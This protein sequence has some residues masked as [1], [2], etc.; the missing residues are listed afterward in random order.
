MNVK[1]QHIV[2]GM[3]T[4]MNVSKFDATKVLYA[5]NIRITQQDN[6][7]G[8]MCV[9][10]EKGTVQCTFDDTIPEGSIVGSAEL[11][12][13]LV[14]FLHTEVSGTPYDSIVKLNPVGDNQFHPVTLM[15]GSDLGFDTEHPLETLAVYENE[16]VQKVYWIDGVHTLR[17]INIADETQRDITDLTQFDANP[18]LELA[19]SLSITKRN[20]GGEFPAGT[21][22]YAFTYHNQYGPESNVFEASPLYELSSKTKGVAADGRTNCSFLINLTNTDTKYK[23]VRIYAIIRT[24]E[25]ATPNVRLLGDFNNDKIN[26]SDTGGTVTVVDD[27]SLG[28]TIDATSLYFVGGEP[29]A[30]STFTV[31]DNTLFLGNI[32]LLRPSIGTLTY[33]SSH[34]LAEKIAELR[35]S[36]NIPIRNTAKTDYTVGSGKWFYDYTIDNN[37][38]STSIRRFKYGETYRLGI[39]AQ[40]KTGIWSEVLWIG[41]YENTVKPEFIGHQT[42]GIWEVGNFNP[43]NVIVRIALVLRDAGFKRIASVVVYPEGKDRTVFCQGLVSATVYNVED[44]F[45]NHPFSQ[46]SWFFRPISE[47]FGIAAIPHAT[48]YPVKENNFNGDSTKITGGAEIQLNTNPRNFLPQAKGYWAGQQATAIVQSAGDMIAMFGNDYYVDTSI[49][50][51]NSPDIDSDDSLQQEDFDDL[52][53]R[54]VGVAYSAYPSLHTEVYMDTALN[55]YIISES[56]SRFQLR[57][58]GSSYTTRRSISFPGYYLPI[59]ASW[60]TITIFDI[61]YTP[62]I[63][64]WQKS[65][66][67]GP[68]YEQEE[69]TPDTTLNSKTFS[70]IWFARTTFLDSNVAVN[71]DTPKLFDDTQSNFIPLGESADSRIYYGNIDSVRL[72]KK[73]MLTA[74]VVSHANDDF[75]INEPQIFG[76]SVQFVSLHRTPVDKNK[77]FIYEGPS[78]ILDS[79]SEETTYFHRGSIDEVI[80]KYG[81]QRLLYKPESESYSGENDPVSIKYK[82]T[83]HAVI[84]LAAQ[85]KHIASLYRCDALHNN[86]LGGNT[87]QVFWDNNEVYTYDNGYVPFITEWPASGDWDNWTGGKDGYKTLT[88]VVP[89]LYIGELY[90]DNI[91]SSKRFGGN[92]EKSLLNNIWKRCGDAVLVNKFLESY[93]TETIKF[94]EGDTYLTRYDCLKTYPYAENDVNSVV[95]IFSTDIET[96]VNLDARYDNARGLLDN[97]LIRPENINLVNRL[98]YEQTNQ[99]F[100]YTTQDYSKETVDSF[101]SSI[102]ISQE[103]ILGSDV[104]I[105]LQTPITSIQD[106]EG[107]YGELKALKTFNNEVFAFQDNAFGQIL[108]NSRVQI[109]TSDGQ[110]IEITNG[111]KYQGIR[112]LSNK[113]GCA[114]KWTIGTSN[115]KMYW[116]DRGS[117]D[118]WS[119]G[120]Q[121]DNLSTRLG[122]K[123][124]VENNFSP[125]WTIGSPALRT[126]HEEGYNDMYFVFG[127]NNYPD[128]G[129][130]V[131]SENLDTFVSVMDYAGASNMYSLNGNT[132]LLTGNSIHRMWGGQYNSFFGINKPYLLRFVANYQPTMHKVFDTVQWRS[133]SWNPAG[134]YL[135]GKTFN[136]LQVWNQYQ[137]TAVTNLTDTPGKPSPLKK[138]FNT[139][140]ALVPRDTLGNSQ[141]DNDYRYKGISRIRGNYAVVELT[142]DDNDNNK[143]QF[144]DLEIGEFI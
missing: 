43:N 49:V 82:S 66:N 106:L 61:A 107:T 122:V 38:P 27:G 42:S 121:L 140:R 84:P 54:I 2:A 120:G 40:Y 129:A 134:K 45:N 97:T 79:T 88:P 58:N 131:Y 63:Y 4:D 50:T 116:Y 39:I 31:K 109:P 132:Y 16:N 15:V 110:P 48:L 87:A 21:I 18:V 37:R 5:R 71:I 75:I 29:V 12:D 20:F 102:A 74:S 113:I 96:R 34:T 83:K 52:K 77:Y 144:Y 103:K 135:P 35:E 130:L 64:P 76:R 108:F 6:N 14:L 59:T 36:D 70:N 92:T 86:V 100:T 117:K 81:Y 93:P 128:Q 10:N 114:D 33:D 91:D 101:P 104:D 69:S 127:N 8:L 73:D 124:F 68:T 99:F 90:R 85:S 32:K 53:F 62:I 143:T 24:S 89:T 41:D 3:T 137:K 9:T 123:G 47:G 60:G 126:I 44:R 67:I 119:F 30:P 46:A 23:F 105:W 7:Q 56:K 138:K 26:T 17:Y 118:I 133:D 72:C 95:E 25:N 94:V 11:N 98:G 141:T 139:F 28:S 13:C 78:I 111:M 136:K 125:N 142:H 80:E 55:Q 51:L 57:L 22:Q 112:Y 115:S 1:E 19:H 65:G